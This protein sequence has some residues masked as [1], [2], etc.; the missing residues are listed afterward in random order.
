MS[1]LRTAG[2]R[3]RFSCFLNILLIVFRTPTDAQQISLH[4]EGASFPDSVYQKWSESYRTYR[5]PK[6]DV[7]LSYKATSSSQGLNLI[8]NAP[9]KA[10]FVGSDNPLSGQFAGKDLDLLIFPTV[11]GGIVIAYNLPSCQKTAGQTLNLTREHVVGIFN[12]T[13]VKWNDPSIQMVNSMCNLPNS[14]IIVIARRVSS[15]TTKTFTSALSAFDLAWKEKKGNFSEGTKEG[16]DI[17]VYWYPDVIRYYGSTN[18]DIGSLVRSIFY[19]LSYL[20][21]GEAESDNNS[22]AAIG[23]INEEFTLP[24]MASLQAAMIYKENDTSL[25]PY[26][27]DPKTPGAYPVSSY[28]YLVFYRTYT[29][30]CATVMEMVRFFMWLTSDPQAQKDA[31]H[32]G[33]STL[34]DRMKQRVHDEVLKKVTCNGELVIDMIE[35]DNEETVETPAWVIPVSITVSACLL[36]F[37]AMAAYIMYQ[38]FKLNSVNHRHDWNIPIEDIVFFYDEKMQLTSVSGR[39]KFLRQKSV[40]SFM[41]IGQISEGPELL[42]QILQWPGKWRGNTIGIRFLDVLDMRKVTRDVENTMLWMRDSLININVVRFYGLTELDGARYVIGDYCSKGTILDI[43]QNGKYNLSEDLKMAV[44]VEI[45]SGMSF[46][47]MHGIVHGMLTSHCCMLDNKWTVKIADWEYCKLF[48]SYKSKMNPLLAFRTKSILTQDKDDATLKSFWTAPEIL[49]SEFTEWPTQSSDVYSYA[50]ILHEVFTRDEPYIELANDMSPEQILQAVVQNRL[51]PE[52]NSDIPMSIRQ[53]MEM[54][55]SDVPSSR[56]SF[57]QMNKMLRRYQRGGKT[58]MDNM[59]ETMEDYT[60]Q[61][62]EEMQTKESTLQSV[63]L[64]LD[65]LMSELVPVDY[66]EAL[67]VGEAIESRIYPALGII[68]LDIEREGDSVDSG[69]VNEVFNFLDKVRSEIKS[70]AARYNAYSPPC[71]YG[72]AHLLLIGIG[73]EQVILY[74]RCVEVSRIALNLLKAMSALEGCASRSIRISAHVGTVAVGSS[75][76]TSPHFFLR[77]SGL[78]VSRSLLTSARPDTVSVSKCLFSQIEKT[79][80]FLFTGRDA[81]WIT[82]NDTD[83]EAFILV[84]SRADP[85]P[86]PSVSLDSGLGGESRDKNHSTTKAETPKVQS[87]NGR[88]TEDLNS[89]GRLQRNKLK[90]ELRRRDVDISADN[91]V[92]QTTGSQAADMP[93]CGT[94]H[95]VKSPENKLDLKVDL[96]PSTDTEAHSAICEQPVDDA[97][98][99]SEHL[100]T[101]RKSSHLG[102]KGKQ[103][104]DSVTNYLKAS[105][106]G[107]KG[108]TAEVDVDLHEPPTTFFIAQ[109][110]PQSSKEKLDIRLPAHLEASTEWVEKYDSRNSCVHEK[111]DHHNVSGPISTINLR[112]LI[113]ES[114]PL[115]QTNDRVDQSNCIDEKLQNSNLKP[116]TKK[117]KLRS[118][119]KQMDIIGDLNEL[120]QTEITKSKKH[121]RHR[122]VLPL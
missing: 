66:M 6:K 20:S 14:S 105:K 88:C 5:S 68:M 115:H 63:K 47:H 96:P 77:G 4:S 79:P 113:P 2:T 9:Q 46:L 119:E 24:T 21:V 1:A 62:E 50:I 118:S 25:T 106:R 71:P 52:P 11:A 67:R 104:S 81:E 107:Y 74:D 80:E 64:D 7:V 103:N 57:E 93:I 35:A 73:Q 39:S 31:D 97:A 13:F 84:G 121:F 99:K 38:R 109:E 18:R 43:L 117:S 92:P 23:N 61:L 114:D 120:K 34:S 116:K 102:E 65:T 49:R 44:A 41:S 26:L 56:P 82:C 48:F 16:T 72:Q 83:I 85:N 122:K 33:F 28:T 94:S 42:S 40:K 55:W 108:S 91:S 32:Y 15:G 89:R 110:L 27:V 98:M 69:H 12:G 75:T 54:A 76:H 53:I 29:T 37:A 45:S 10:N 8:V 60:N 22:Y 100:Q 36:L 86:A 111:T 70:A 78:D 3:S 101:F 58:I 30:D 90:C 95:L 17:P 59:M 51:R 112:S 87:L 19:S